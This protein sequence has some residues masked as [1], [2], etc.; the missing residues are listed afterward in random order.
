MQPSMMTSITTATIK[1]MRDKQTK[2]VQQ[3]KTLLKNEVE[4]RASLTRSLSHMQE[5]TDAIVNSVPWI[6]VWINDDLR[7][8]E[9]NGF[10]AELIGS[11]PRS[12]EGKSLGESD[13]E[14]QLSQFIT[15]FIANQNITTKALELNVKTRSGQQFFLLTA[16]KYNA[17]QAISLVGQDINVQKR[18]QQRLE[19]LNQS[20]DQQVQQ[21][22]EKLKESCDKLKQTKSQL[23]QSEK[24]ASIGTM[25]AGI[26]HELNNPLGFI[27]CN[28]DLLRNH[29]NELMPL[30]NALCEDEIKIEDLTKMKADIKNLDWHYLMEDIEAILQESKIGTERVSD[31]VNNMKDVSRVEDGSQ[32]NCDIKA[33]IESSLMLCQNNLKYH[34]QIEQSVKVS[35][36]VQCSPGE[37][38]Q[39]LLNLINNAAYAI[40]EKGIISIRAFEKNGQCCIEVQ[41]NGKGIP[42]HQLESIFDPF[43]TTKPAGQGTGLGLFVSHG[44]IQKHGGSLTVD[45]CEKKGSCFR[46]TLPLAEETA[47]IH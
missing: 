8:I 41:D 47:S 35:H 38:N 1:S 3:L 29:F 32:K 2:E 37:L 39:I 22:T 24:L 9:V 15:E 6:V 46:I 13:L 27:I 7:Y 33:C 19:K 36:K 23:I 40:D 42:S 31:I 28:L 30:L 17:G 14:S 16:H 10:F 5:R 44:I 34:C 11:A 26:A 12:L 21:R 25:A 4:N 18:Y 20:L 45:S 43:F